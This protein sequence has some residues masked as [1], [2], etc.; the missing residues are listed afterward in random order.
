MQASRKIIAICGGGNLA[1]ASIAAIGHHN[2]T[3]EIRI[4]SRRPEVWGPQ[5]V[6]K[7]EGSSWE[8]K[9]ELVG[10]ISVSS[11]KAEDVIPGADVIIICSPAHTKIEIL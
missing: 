4:L 6:G 2:P 1:H 3:F 7:T 8:S 11:S 10:K 9:G 5:I